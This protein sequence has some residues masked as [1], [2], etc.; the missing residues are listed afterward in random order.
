MEAFR[1]PTH[2]YLGSKKGLTSFGGTATSKAAAGAPAESNGAAPTH[3]YDATPDRVVSD[4]RNPAT[5]GCS[6]RR[7]A[8]G[9]QK[10]AGPRRPSQWGAAP[11]RGRYERY[12]TAGR[13]CKP[14]AGATRQGVR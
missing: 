14:A 3:V 13:H 4:F 9:C 1:C 12:A 10:K 11:D 2:R 7:R 5:A 8:A 6:V